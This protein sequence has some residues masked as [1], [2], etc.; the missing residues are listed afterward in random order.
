M[1]EIAA[2]CYLEEVLIG[3]NG[4]SESLEV[5]SYIELAHRTEISELANTLN[6]HLEMRMFVVG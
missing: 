1:K 3:K 4:S 6:D 2:K 5:L